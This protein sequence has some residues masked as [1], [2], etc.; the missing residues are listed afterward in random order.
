MVFVIALMGAIIV[1]Y[2]GVR[3]RFG[4]PGGRV[5]SRAFRHT[6]C[7]R[8]AG[9]VGRCCGRARIAAGGALTV[10]LISVGVL[11]A[12]GVYLAYLL[13]FNREVLDTEP[14]DVNVFTH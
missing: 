14:G 6:G 5:R 2:L 9:V 4:T 3:K 11:V 13:V 12:G 7:Y 1:L 8:R 10:V